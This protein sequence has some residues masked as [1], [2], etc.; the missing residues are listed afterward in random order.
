MPLDYLTYLNLIIWSVTHL[1]TA[2]TEAKNKSYR[3]V[4][5]HLADLLGVFGA[6]EAREALG[7]ELAAA[8]VEARAVVLRELRAEGVE[9]DHYRASVRL[10]LR[11]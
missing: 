7:V 8:R 3:V 1:G 11:A 6:L 5:G 10:E 9:R 4:V 2:H